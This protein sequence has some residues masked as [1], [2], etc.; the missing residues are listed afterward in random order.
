M[1]IL[2]ANLKHLYQRRGLWV[3]YAFF[4]LFAFVGVVFATDE[5]AAGE[6]KFIGLVLL[7]FLVGLVVATQQ[8]EIVAKPF[9][10]CLPGHRWVLREFIFVVGGVANLAGCLMFLLYPGLPWERVLI[11][12]CSAFFAGMVFY[13]GGVWLALH[14]NQ[15]V[16]LVGLL[17]IP[18][19]GGAYLKLHIFL[20]QAIVECPLLVI[21]FGLL[22]SAVMWVGLGNDDLVR[23]SCLTP[24]LGFGDVFNRDR[25]LRYQKKVGAARW[26]K[27]RLPSRPWVEEFFIGR[28]NRQ[29]PFGTARFLWGSLYAS[30]G[31]LSFLR[32]RNVFLLVLFIAVFLGYMGPTM[33][34]MLAFMPSMFVLASRPALYSKMLVVGRA[35]RFSSTLAVVVAATAVLTMLA[36]VVVLTSMALARI[37]PEFT[38]ADFKFVYRVIDARVLYVPLVFVPLV[39]AIHLVFYR[40]PIAMMTVFMVIASFLTI[41][42][43]RGGSPADVATPQTIVVLTSSCWLAFVLVAHHIAMRRCL[44]K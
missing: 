15:P 16:A 5:R 30:F 39:Y 14:S 36:G 38:Y 21:A 32:G 7:A 34:I 24:W 23:R 33:W 4:G 6:G 22:C 29:S 42:F 10:S 19:V 44:V 41:G 43:G 18:M 3:A 11:V 37:I 27:L 31:P 2:I 9:G 13:L 28:M 17:F 26:E 8:R 20:E 35:E 1:R 12:L 25:A 40:S